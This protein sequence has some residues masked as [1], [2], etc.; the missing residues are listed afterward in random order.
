MKDYE[1]EPVIAEIIWRG[2]TGDIYGKETIDLNKESIS[3]ALG[4]LLRKEW[5]SIESGDSFQFVEV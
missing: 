4:R 1:Y 3:Q 2:P 5:S